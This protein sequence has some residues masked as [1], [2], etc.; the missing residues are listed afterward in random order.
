MGLNV[1]LDGRVNETELG[2]WKTRRD[3]LHG[4]GKDGEGS[5][6]RNKVPKF[7]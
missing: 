4:N 5:E 3:G 1:I 6:V 7:R 2:K